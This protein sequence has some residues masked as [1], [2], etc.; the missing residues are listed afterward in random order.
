[1]SSS[2]IPDP[3]SLVELDN[4]WTLGYAVD[5]DGVSWPWLLAPHEAPQAGCDCARCAPH[6]QAGRLPPAVRVRLSRCEALTRST[7]ERCR[8]AA[9]VGEQLCYVHARSESVTG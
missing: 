3:A 2:S 7:G 8:N 1:M 6:E 4:G 5:P 9:S